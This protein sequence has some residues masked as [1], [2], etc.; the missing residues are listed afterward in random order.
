MCKKT[1]NVSLEYRNNNPGWLL[2]FKAA[3]GGGGGGRGGGGHCKLS[4]A[5]GNTVLGKNT[6]SS[7]P[8]FPHVILIW[9]KQEMNVSSL[10]FSFIKCLTKESLLAYAYSIT[11]F[12]KAGWEQRRVLW[13]PSS[14]RRQW[15]LNYRTPPEAKER[16]NFLTYSQSTPSSS[17]PIQS[18]FWKLHGSIVPPPYGDCK[19]LSVKSNL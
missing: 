17:V 2:L 16:E 14:I 1:P 9:Y 12:V 18:L 5:E 6:I 19:P 10:F 11:V 8:F 15:R 3:G 7:W 4:P 13:E